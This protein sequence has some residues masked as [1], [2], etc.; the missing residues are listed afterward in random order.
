MFGKASFI[1]EKDG[2]YLTLLRYIEANALRA[3]LSKTAQD[4]QYGSL[5][6]RVF[7]N[8]ILLHKPY[9]QLDDWMTYVNTPQSQSEIDKIRDSVNRQAPLG[10]ENWAAKIAKKYGLL[11]TLNAIGR[12]KNDD[13]SSLSLFLL[14]FLQAS[15]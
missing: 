11:S 4:W 6:E 14:L 8:R 9:A 12:V 3:A 2:Y 5:A 10:G 1:V 7:N 15:C 13:K